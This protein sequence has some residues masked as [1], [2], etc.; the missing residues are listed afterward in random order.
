MVSRY[1]TAAAMLAAGDGLGALSQVGRDETPEGLALC[2]CAFAQIGDFERAQR[3]LARA[4]RGFGAADPI[5][6]ARCV[7]ASAEVSLAT[8]ELTG[9]LSGLRQASAALSASGDLV[10]A[11]HARLVLARSLM[12]L[13]QQ[14]EAAQIL[15]RVSLRRAPPLLAATAELIRA[16]L[17]LRQVEIAQ[18][19]AALSRA[20]RA[21]ERAAIPALV[22]EITRVKEGLLAPAARLIAR[23]EVRV[24]PLIEVE[25]V[26]AKGA[27]LVDACRR[28]LRC[29]ARRV[30]F[31]GKPVLLELMCCLA[32]AWPEVVPRER[33]IERGFGARRSNETHRARLRVELGRLRRLLAKVGSIQAEGAGYRLVAAD[34]V[35]VLLPATAHEHAA[36]LALLSDGASWSSSALALALGASQRTLQRALLSLEESGRVVGRGQGR[37]RRW[38]VAPLYALPPQLFGLLALRA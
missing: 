34:N 21:A 16:E 9:S 10:N 2:G 7:T 13:D 27:W 3:F 26:L 20:Q 19:R 14:V 18:A 24:L 35:Q 37:A 15:E 11:L 8:R 32:E 36:L 31:V 1:Q 4:A 30:S 23:G 38:S 6:R 5:A 29:G 17:A 12:F 22:R 33:L 25:R 28:E